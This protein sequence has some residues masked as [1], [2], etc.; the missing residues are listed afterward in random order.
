MG[1]NIIFHLK[2]TTC[3]RKMADSC[4][5]LGMYRWVLEHFRPES[6]NALKNNGVA[7]ENTEASLRGQQLAK[8]CQFDYQK[9]NNDY[10]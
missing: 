2:E 6:K 4:L 5:G 7:W 8:F 10:G 1:S 9:G 3:F